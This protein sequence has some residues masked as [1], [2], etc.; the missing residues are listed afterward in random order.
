MVLQHPDKAATGGAAEAV[1]ASS[2][3]V[4]FDDPLHRRVRQR[5]VPPLLAAVTVAVLW[6]LL[7]RVAQLVPG[8]VQTVG[9]AYSLLTGGTFFFH[10]WESL[11]RV[12]VGFV[13]AMTLSVIVGIVMGT[14]TAGE[15]YFRPMVVI[16]LTV[17]GLIWALI[18][19]MIFGLSEL[20]AYFAVTVTIF[21]MLVITIW[22]AVKSMDRD[23]IDMSAVLRLRPWTKVRTVILPQLVPSIFSATRYGLGLAWKV[24]VVVELF[25]ASTGIG[26]QINRAYQLF[27]LELVLAWTALFVVVML[28]IEHMLVNPAE[29]NLT[30]WRPEVNVWRR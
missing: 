10:M 14:S 25:G 23:L 27:S 22:G 13:T 29:R 20:T 12:L 11:R 7:S 24:V 28:G 21:P 4:T 16:G 17:P 19:V 2:A 15:R 9:E 1:T 30:A 6:F 3:P 5:V 26:Y 8:P 18:S